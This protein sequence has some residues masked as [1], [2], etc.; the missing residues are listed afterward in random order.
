MEFRAPRGECANRRGRGGNAR[1][2]APRIRIGG[3]IGTDRS[4]SEPIG[5]GPDAHAP[6]QDRDQGAGDSRGGLARLRAAS[7]PRGPDRRH[8]RGR[9]H[10]QG[11]DLP[12]LPDQGGPLLRDDP[13]RPRHARRHRRAR[14]RART[15][16]ATAPR[17]DRRARSRNSSGT[18]DTCSRCCRR[19]TSETSSATRRCCGGAGRSSGSSRR[20]FS[21]ASSAGSFAASTRGSRGDVPRDGARRSSSSADPEDTLAGADRAT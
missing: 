15:L 6:S 21:R 3:N 16:S 8:R 12:V 4:V 2:D 17:A 19:R 11:D 7:V 1:C 10:R 14:D 9:L 18:S 13:A 5:R 20:R